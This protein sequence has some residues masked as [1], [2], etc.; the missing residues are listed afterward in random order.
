MTDLLPFC[1]D[2]IADDGGPVG[3]ATGREG[4]G[5]PAHIQHPRRQSTL[6]LHFLRGHGGA[7]GGGF[8]RQRD[9][10]KDW[11]RERKRE[12]R[13]GGGGKVEKKR[14]REGRGEGWWNDSQREKDRT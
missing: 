7:W 11:E 5:L 13:G 4:R 3:G 1:T 2:C 8:C 10:R 12:G 6:H 9:R 14:M